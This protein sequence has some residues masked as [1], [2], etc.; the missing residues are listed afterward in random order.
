MMDGDPDRA[1]AVALQAEEDALAREAEEVVDELMGSRVRI[2]Q[3]RWTLG[4]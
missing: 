3:D 1:V 2:A 4:V